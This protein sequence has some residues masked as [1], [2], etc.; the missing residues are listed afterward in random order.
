MSCFCYGAE[1]E[2]RLSI[3]TWTDLLEDFIREVV[4]EPVYVV[5][6][7]LGGYLAAQLAAT[8]QHLC[9]CSILLALPAS[10]LPAEHSQHRWCIH[11]PSVIGFEGCPSGCVQMLTVVEL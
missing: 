10:I 8:R 9:R 7:S 6:N 3:D 2:L 4:R 5:G 1:E 11:V